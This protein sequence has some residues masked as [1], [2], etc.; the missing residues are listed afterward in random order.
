MSNIYLVG[1]MGTGKTAV[2]RELAKKKKW[3]FAD[4]DALIELKEKKSISDIFASRGERYFRRIE[5]D[6]LEEVS[7]ENN[8]VFAC[9]GGIVID[10]NNIKTMKATGQVVCLCATPEVII[11]RTSGFSHR[12]LLNVPDPK[13]RIELLLKLRSPYYARAD[14]VFDTSEL[15]VDEVARKIIKAISLPE[16]KNRQRASKPKKQEKE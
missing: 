1:F 9:G 13:K 8:F 3:R 15:S 11:K 2:G 7:K 12:P 6:I 5:S 14:R 4:L 10:E 16:Q